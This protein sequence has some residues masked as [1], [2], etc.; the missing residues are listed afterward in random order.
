MA[1]LEHLNDG[2]EDCPLIR[3]YDFEP[4]DLGILTNACVSL[5]QGRLTELSLD[6]QPWVAVVGRC[7][8]M[9]RAGSSNRGIRYHAADGSFVMEY[10]CEGWMEVA[11]K[12]QALALARRG[13]QWLT[14]EGDLPLLASYDGQW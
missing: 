1:K 7:Q 13:F 6:D 10:N 14:N 4:S 5:A 3:L 9:L 11:E 8:F 12:L 2:S